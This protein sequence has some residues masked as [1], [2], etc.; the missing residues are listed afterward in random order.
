[1]EDEIEE[2]SKDWWY[3]I[4]TRRYFHDIIFYFFLEIAFAIMLQWA[5]AYQI[6]TNPEEN[7]RLSKKHFYTKV[8]GWFTI[9]FTIVAIV[10]IVL[11]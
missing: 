7:L 4:S 3:E 6:L 1:M 8:L 2:N 11:D 10:E 9:I 5:K